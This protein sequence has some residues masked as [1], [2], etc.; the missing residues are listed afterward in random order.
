LRNVPLAR[1]GDL[2]NRVNPQRNPREKV[3]ERYAGDLGLRLPPRRSDSTAITALST[4]V[5]E[6]R[7]AV[8]LA[9]SNRLNLYQE[10]PPL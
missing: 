3:G 5:N 7:A 4:K 8:H 1:P 9:V 10:R 6:E 2:S